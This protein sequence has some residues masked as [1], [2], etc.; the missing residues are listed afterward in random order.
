MTRA[1]EVLWELAK[2]FLNCPR[3]S[4]NVPREETDNQE[5]KKNFFIWLRWVLFVVCRLLSSCG[6]W[7]C[8]GL[9]CPNTYGILVPWPGIETKSPEL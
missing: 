9:S 3:G 2:R 8:S 5:L 1:F 7:A 6:A 4:E